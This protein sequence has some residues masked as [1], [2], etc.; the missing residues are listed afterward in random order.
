MRIVPPIIAGVYLLAA[1]GLHYLFPTAKLINSPYHFIG[2]IFVVVSILIGAWAVIAFKKKGTTHKID[3][4][5]SALVTNGPYGFSR[6]PMYVSM[7]ILLLGIA[8]YVGT[9]PLFLSPA[10]FVLTIN[11]V[12]IPREEMILENIF[13]QEYLKYKKNVRRWL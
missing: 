11:T 3:E 6:N 9:T 2:I 4:K 7:A 8:I 10:A 5:P 13:G 1:L 12:Y